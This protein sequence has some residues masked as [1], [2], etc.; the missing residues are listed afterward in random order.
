[1]I[2]ISQSKD[3][4]KK[5]YESKLQKKEKIRRI[6]STNERT[7]HFLLNPNVTCKITPFTRKYK[8]LLEGV[9][10]LRE[11]EDLEVEK[12]D[13]YVE[14]ME[15]ETL[16]EEE[17]YPIVY[18][19]A[20]FFQM[21]LTGLTRLSF[22]VA[23]DPFSKSQRS[24]YY[25]EVFLINK[26]SDLKAWISPENR[27]SQKYPASTI[28]YIED[29]REGAGLKINDDRKVKINL[30]ELM[31]KAKEG[32]A[33]KMLLLTVKCFDLKKAPPK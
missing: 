2:D 21:E 30:G 7:V 15:T 25:P 33:G 16:P 23:D 5:A 28:E 11:F 24:K 19:D 8:R 32:Q 13:K 17:Q 31:K 4:I 20:P 29:F 3:N 27:T 14:A 9:D 1:M 6:E 10:R 22:A 18:E 12:F 26:K